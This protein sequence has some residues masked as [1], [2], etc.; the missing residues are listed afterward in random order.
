MATTPQVAMPSY[1]S[2]LTMGDSW[3]RVVI[4]VDNH[5][6]GQGSTAAGAHVS[7][8]T[9]DLTGASW[10]LSSPTPGSLRLTRS[11]YFRLRADT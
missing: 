4:S 6:P 5:T 8:E 9:L 3:V 10:L 2:P 11:P 1:P 7:R